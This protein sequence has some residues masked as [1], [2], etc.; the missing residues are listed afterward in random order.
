MRRESKWAG[1]PSSM[2]VHIA[3]EAEGLLMLADCMQIASTSV[4]IRCEGASSVT[5]R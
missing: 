1:I 5:T 4:W 3:A 2:I